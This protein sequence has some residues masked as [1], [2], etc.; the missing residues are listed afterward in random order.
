[1]SRGRPTLCVAFALLLFCFAPFALASA[2]QLDEPA[3]RVCGTDETGAMM[4]APDPMV[5]DKWIRENRITAGGV[6]PVNFHV[7]YNSS[8]GEGNVPESWLDA[9]IVV[10][11]ST[12]AGNGYNN[13]SH[14]GD[15]TGYTFVKNSVTRTGNRQWFTMTPGTAKETQAKSALVVNPQGSLNLYTCKPGQGLL[16]WATFPWS[17]ASA[18]SKDGVV[19]HYASLPGGSLSPYNLGGTATHEVGHWVG[20]YHTFQGGCNSDATCSSA[21]DLVCDTPAEGT[22]TS[23]CPSSKNTCSGAGNDPVHN[24]MDYSTDACYT[25]FTAGQDSR[26]D[27]MMS[28]YRPQ[29]GSAPAKSSAGPVASA[30][31][32]GELRV[33]PNPFNPTT[34]IDFALQRDGHV[35]L[36]VYDVAGREVATLIDGERTAGNHRAV[37][38][39]A[40]LSSGIYMAVLD[41]GAERVTQRLVLLK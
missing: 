29:I 35:S 1:M 2:P 18:P 22:A 23:G 4:V 17:L 30:V 6:I 24:Y 36:R 26:A 20:L 3:G 9:Q 32:S 33:S 10:L 16:G 12:F 8:T 13:G 5:I 41:T 11:N 25:Q 40:G 34:S 19:V 39:G 37:F 7:I 27:F 14:T 31:R 21:G 38:T 28:T 15:N